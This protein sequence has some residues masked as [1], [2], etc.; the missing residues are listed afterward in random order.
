MKLAKRLTSNYKRDPTSNIG[1]L[2]SVIDLEM[3]ELKKAIQTVELYRKIDNATGVTLDNIGKNVLQDRG[4]MDDV[5]Y[6]LYLK[7]KV[8]A[9]LSG[10]QIETLNDVLSVLLDDNFISVREVWNNTTYGNEPAAV[11]TRYIN[12]FQDIRDQ[13]KGLIDDP[14]Y[15]DGTY[16]LDGTR[17]LDGGFNFIYSDAEQQI[18]DAMAETKK[19]MQFIKAGGVAV[20]WC[21]P[22]TILTGTITSAG[23]AKII[24]LGHFPTVTQIGFGTG[25]HNTVS[26]DPLLIDISETTVPGEVV[27]KSIE[28]FML[29]GSVAQTYAILEQNEGNGESISAYGLYDA[30]DDLIA[31]MYTNPSPKTVDTRIEITWNQTF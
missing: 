6:R 22:I 16:K 30:D 20:H 15:L 7:V 19:M 8:R 12:F 26:G 21:E 13:Y 5:T 25:G 11:E 18:I 17:Y 10:G 4:A 29:T 31:L 14:W 3:D 28:S 2:M 23:A 27:K 1:K 9:N 24:S